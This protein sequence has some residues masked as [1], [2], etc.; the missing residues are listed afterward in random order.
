MVPERRICQWCDSM[1][2][3][4]CVEI[5]T[6]Q[7]AARGMTYC[8]LWSQENNRQMRIGVVMN[9]DQHDQL[10]RGHLG[11]GERLSVPAD[12]A[13]TNAYRRDELQRGHHSVCEG[14]PAVANIAATNADQGDQLLRGRPS[15][16]E[17]RAVA[18]AG[19]A[20]T[21]AYQRDQ[22]QRGQPGES[23]V[24][25]VAADIAAM[26]ADHRHADQRDRLQRCHLSTD[27]GQ[28]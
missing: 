4:P 26:K 23:E 5:H 17:G 9:A 12:I 1:L 20:A 18:A 11:V 21:N 25:A 15:V 28:A 22:L 3:A 19:I 14:Q 7:V 16:K 6:Y 27:E 24:R 2:C 13:L 8:Q 10:Q